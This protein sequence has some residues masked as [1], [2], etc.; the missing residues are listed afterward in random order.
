MTPLDGTKAIPHTIN[1]E[2]FFAD[3]D[4]L[5]SVRADLIERVT[6]EAFFRGIAVGALSAIGTILTVW[7]LW[8]WL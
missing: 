4:A 6:T 7:A 8:R 2:Q 3:V 1:L 5:D